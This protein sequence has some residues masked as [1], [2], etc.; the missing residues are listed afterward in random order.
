MGSHT[1]AFAALRAEREAARAAEAQAKAEARAL[2]DAER[3]AGK[4]SVWMPDAGPQGPA[5]PNTRS[6]LGPS[7]QTQAKEA[8]VNT[9]TTPSTTPS[10]I[11][12]RE[13]GERTSIGALQAGQAFYRLTSGKLKLQGTV[14]AVRSEGRA[15]YTLVFLSPAGESKTTWGGSATMFYTQKAGSPELATTTDGPEAQEG[16]AK[17]MASKTS[18][19]PTPEATPE[20]P[21]TPEATPEVPQVDLHKELQA[22]L[23]E[24]GVK[25]TPKWS[26]SKK[27]AA[28]KQADGKT[29]AYVFAQTS[30]GIKVKACLE[31]KELDRAAKKSWLDNSKEAPFSIRGFF[32]QEN[33]GQAVAA[34]KATAAKLEA[35]KVA[36]SMAKT[37]AKQAAAKKAEAKQAEP[38]KAPAKKASKPADG[39]PGPKGLAQVLSPDQPAE[40]VQA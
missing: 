36:K 8:E 37:E 3:L 20:V 1:E 2:A 16:D 34:I 26:P 9:S 27:Y 21:Q 30:S 22:Q 10:P 18:T 29:L 31:M 15:G 28:Y 24:A 11:L 17:A 19:T 5:I 40:E 32:T 35:A 14:V 23:K 7:R 13:Q 4:D 25:V 33:L 39:T 6:I 38:K 12:P